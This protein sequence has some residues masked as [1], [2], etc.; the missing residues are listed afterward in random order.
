MY[1]ES[2]AA[3]EAIRTRFA[4]QY[5]L[6]YPKAIE[7]LE[8][9]W[10]RLV[11]F[12]AFPMDHSLHLRTTDIVESPFAAVRL[13]TTTAKRYKKAEHATALIWKALGVAERTFRR[14]NA[15][16][17]RRAVYAGVTYSDG[18]A[19]TPLPRRIAA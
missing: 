6:A 17:I 13:R 2:R 11:S 16:E 9:D 15:L 10:E 5:R 3:R 12:F 19:V 1:A 18:V 7:T 4:A 8:R 14:L